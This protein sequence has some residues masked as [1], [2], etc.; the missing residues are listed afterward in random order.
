MRSRQVIQLIRRGFREG[1]VLLFIII[2]SCS[3]T[4]VIDRTPSNLNGHWH[5]VD[6]FGDESIGFHYIFEPIEIY[7]DTVIAIGGLFQDFL[8]DQGGVDLGNEVIYLRIG[9]SYLPFK[10]H[11]LSNDSL[12]LLENSMYDSMHMVKV[13]HTNKDIYED[14]TRDSRI[15]VR[16]PISKTNI[17]SDSISLSLISHLQI[18]YGIDSLLVYK[19]DE[20]NVLN[21]IN[22]SDLTLQIER[23]RVKLPESMR[24]SI[25]PML[26]IDRN[27]PADVLVEISTNYRQLGFDSLLI[28]YIYEMT[29][30]TVNV[31]YSRVATE[32]ITYIKGVKGNES[33]ANLLSGVKN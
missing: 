14:I 23:H 8:M 27:V 22:L 21:A 31:K 12:L 32:R 26:T 3:D 7:N 9:H 24:S 17:E 28:S 15:N 19:I 18:G 13:K 5:I 33:F 30:T 1:L 11:I 2:F 29:D 6:E 16:P 10:Y 4:T 25:I 20:Y